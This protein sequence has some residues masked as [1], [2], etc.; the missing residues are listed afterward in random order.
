[1]GEDG[2]SA[3]DF[4]T[5]GPTRSPFG[6][7]NANISPFAESGL[8]LYQASCGTKASQRN[9][10]QVRCVSYRRKAPGNIDLSRQR[11]GRSRR[12]G[13]RLRVASNHKRAGHIEYTALVPGGVNVFRRAI[14]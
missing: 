6:N 8:S 2:G 14:C 9:N 1:M 3:L 5:S 7:A 13:Y 4:H 12:Y 10:P 11:L